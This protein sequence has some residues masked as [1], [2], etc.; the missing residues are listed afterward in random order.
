MWM[1]MDGLCEEWRGV[2]Q[3]DLVFSYGFSFIFD[4]TVTAYEDPL[5]WV[6]SCYLLNQSKFV[7]F[8]NIKS[9]IFCSF[10]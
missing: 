2:Q 4:Q 6:V 8:L 1:E 5:P 9:F 10:Y 7:S 3:V